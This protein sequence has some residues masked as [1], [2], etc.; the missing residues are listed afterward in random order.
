MNDQSTAMQQHKPTRVDA[1]LSQVM[2]PTD[3][4]S[5][6]RALP[7]HI[8]FERF[9]RN[10]SNALMNEP[11]LLNMNPREAFREVAKI[12]ALGLL[13]DAQLGE[14]YLI[15]SRT[16]PQARVGYRG[17]IK[18]ARQSADV[19]MITRMRFMSAM[20]SIASSATKST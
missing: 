14:A 8:P 17:L 10:L 18:L 1:F 16:G 9:E 20:R 2:T 4:D 6:R 19:A 5:I 15:A 11:K 12:A 7:A 3:R 13:I